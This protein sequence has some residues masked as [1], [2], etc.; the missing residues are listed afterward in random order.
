MPRAW[1]V[2][3]EMGLV[4][5]Q[6]GLKSQPLE[7]D[8]PVQALVPGLPDRAHAAF[9][10]PADQPVPIGDEESSCAATSSL[11]RV[12]ASSLATQSDV[13]RELVGG[14]PQASAAPGDSPSVGPV[15]GFDVT[16]GEL[17]GGAAFGRR[18][19]P[20]LLRSRIG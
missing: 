2:R 12:R 5:G 7:R 17:A 14:C 15:N 18:R 1:C 4:F 6:T 8:P 20:I 9:A 10:D 13:L 16:F 11:R 3:G 19:R